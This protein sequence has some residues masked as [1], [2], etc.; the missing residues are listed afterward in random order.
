MHAAF[1][2][3]YSRRRTWRKCRCIK[4]LTLVATGPDVSARVP[5]NDRENTNIAIGRD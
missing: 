3:A 2:A 5:V 1:W 4:S